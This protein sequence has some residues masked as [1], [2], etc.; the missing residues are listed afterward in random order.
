MLKPIFPK[1]LHQ[2]MKAE[3]TDLI[4]DGIQAPKK[5]ERERE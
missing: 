2:V 3:I 1:L 5:K 4:T